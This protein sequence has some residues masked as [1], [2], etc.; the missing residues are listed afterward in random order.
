[1]S[2]DIG[3]FYHKLFFRHGVEGH[4]ENARR[5]TAIL[6]HLLDTGWLGRLVRTEFSAA[7]PEQVTWLHDAG[8]VEDLHLISQQGGGYLDLDTVA[9]AET[10][11]AALMAAGASMTAAEQVLAGKLRAALA[12]VR[13]PGHHARASQGMGFCFFNNAALAAEAALRAGAER[14][15]ILDWD[16][17][18]GNGT[19]ELFY[20]RADVLYLSIHQ[21]YTPGGGGL[22]YPGTGTL[23]EYGVDEGRGTTVNVPL[24][25]AAT[26]RDYLAAFDLVLLPALRQYRPELVIVSAGYDAHHADPLGQMLLSAPG[27]HAMSELLVEATRQVESAG[28]VLILE[29]GY[30]LRGLAYG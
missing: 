16:C 20:N 2:A 10:Y 6:D 13:P 18:H 29:G 30:D 15:A 9:T 11:E 5:L 25:G 7:S 3:L 27:F 21:A 12:L 19:Q 23:D 17:H 14:V 24:P 1:M 28:P 4:P 26:D 8:Y 22:F